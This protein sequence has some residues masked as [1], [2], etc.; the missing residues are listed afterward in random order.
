MAF[1]GKATY[2]AF[3]AELVR[4]VSPVISLLSPR[5]TPFLE[6][7]GDPRSFFW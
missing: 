2:S 7:I 4:D 6:F 3:A 1:S 5:R